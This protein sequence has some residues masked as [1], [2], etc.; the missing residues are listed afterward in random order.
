MTKPQPLAPR[1]VPAITRRQPDATTKAPATEK[2]PVEELADYIANRWFQILGPIRTCCY[3]CRAESPVVHAPSGT[4]AFG[5]HIGRNEKD[6]TRDVML[7]FE[8]I[9]W[10]FQHKKSYCPQCKGLGSA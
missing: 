2:D 9:G 10:K 1:P 8:K 3:R 4:L 7:A 5:Q 6:I